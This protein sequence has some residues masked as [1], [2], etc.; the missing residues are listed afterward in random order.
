MSKPAEAHP[1]DEPA[2][3]DAD[4]MQLFISYSRRD[5]EAAHAMVMA[6]EAEGFAVTI[7]TRDLP[8]GEEW[9]QELRDFIHAADTVIWLVSPDSVGSR[10]VNW[11]L[12]EV[13][14]AGKRLFPVVVRETTPEDLPEALGKLHLLPAKGMFQVVDHLPPL[15]AALHTD[16]GWVKEYTRLGMI[17]RTWVAGGQGTDRLLR[18]RALKAAQDWRIRRPS[19]A[20]PADPAILD[21]LAASEHGA[22]RRQRSLIASLAGVAVLLAGLAVYALVKQQEAVENEQLAERRAARMSVSAAERLRLDGFVTES[23]L[24]LLN[25]ASYFTDDDATGGLRIEM[26]RALERQSV[27]KARVLLPPGTRAK[28]EGSIL[29]LTDADEQPVPMPLP[30]V[31]ARSTSA[32]EPFLCEVVF[33]NPSFNFPKDDFYDS[34]ECERKGSYILVHQ[35]YLGASGG[36]EVFT[37]LMDGRAD[38]I[39]QLDQDYFFQDYHWTVEGTTAAFVFAEDNVLTHYT[40]NDGELSDPE[41]LVLDREAGTPFL[42]SPQHLLVVT[43]FNDAYDRDEDQAERWVMEFTLGGGP[44]FVD[45]IPE[46][47]SDEFAELIGIEFAAKA[48]RQ[49]QSCI[50]ASDY[51]S[52]LCTGTSPDGSWRYETDEKS[53]TLFK[54]DDPAPVTQIEGRFGRGISFHRDGPELVLVDP[55]ESQNV[56]IWSPGVDPGDAWTSRLIY[57]STHPIDSAETDPSGDVLIV[58]FSPEPKTIEGIAYAVSARKTWRQFGTQYPFAMVRVLKDG[59]VFAGTGPGGVHRFPPLSE[60]SASLEKAVPD[61]CR[62]QKTKTDEPG[63]WRQ[64]PCWPDWID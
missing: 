29:R 24:V 31:E 22:K 1:A 54:T 12:G 16:R 15:V 7:D 6:L 11:E 48:L 56:S 41:A 49:P 14:R 40:L 58:A 36:T 2:L 18:G 27:E 13:Q 44:S 55:D 63:Y 10:W 43:G 38:P 34:H 9:Q 37:I 64:S 50:A 8:F 33:F 20:P 59:R 51:L 5:S 35:S 4:R 19:A 45:P 30:G 25:S 61:R 21:L 47:P 60:L 42:I 28:I 23:M 53:L 32:P 39:F 57:R 26:E 62:P 17:A 46:N 52:D 3:P